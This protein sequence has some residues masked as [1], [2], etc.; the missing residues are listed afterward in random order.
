MSCRFS[1]ARCPAAGAPRS[2]R[3]FRARF[4]RSA[5]RS[6]PLPFP[7]L[8]SFLHH[9]EE[10]GDL[11]RIPVEVDPEYEIAEIVT[12]VVRED[13]PAL[14]FERPRGSRFPVVANVLGAIRRCEWALGRPPEA[15]GE[16]LLEAAEEVMPPS[17]GGLWRARDVLLRG[18]HL[19]VRY[20]RR[21]PVQA[22]VGNLDLGDLPV[23]TCWPED[24]GPFVTFPLVVTAHPE[25]GT[26]NL[27]IY[28]MH[29]YDGRRTGMHWQIMKGGGY[30]YAE[31][32]RRDEPL[33]VAVALGADPITLLASVAPLPEGID[34]LAFA[35]F[36][37]GSPTEMARCG[38]V[39]A[40]A[41]ASAEFVLEGFV[42]PDER[43][44]EGPF[45]DH[46]GH[47]SHAAPFP[48]FHLER[49]TRRRD[50]VY[51]AAVVGKPP[52]E[53]KAMGEAVAG[54]VGPLIKLV[55]PEVVDLHAFFE[56]GFHNL[57]VVAVAQ[58]YRKEAMKTALS[59]MGQ[60]Q[61][62]LTKVAILVDPDV[63]VEDWDAV[64]DAFRRHWSAAEDALLLPGVPQDTLDFTSF[65]M[66][67]GSKLALDCTSGA[68]G[69]SGDA[70]PEPEEGDAGLDE[71]PGGPDAPFVAPDEREE[72]IVDWRTWRDTLCVARVRERDGRTGRAVAESLAASPER[73]RIKW[74]AVV[75]DDVPLDDRT[76]LLW[77]IFT[78]FDAARDV[79]FSTMDMDGAW[80][81]YAGRMAIDA[82]WKPG[83]PNPIEPHPGIARRVDERWE[84]YGIS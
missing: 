73:G 41:P 44:D 10:R 38:A 33:P 66:N 25:T 82:T 51:P 74:A 52:Q 4:P 54:I 19:R 55:Q 39:E 63:A 56:A 62:A 9:C 36:L 40:A 29:V 76:L 46:F 34:E 64:L 84:E 3:G 7:D 65:R 49:I 15:I 43:A 26:R 79:V 57:L 18:R 24:G 53:D 8:Q 68:G 20:P 75:S 71:L 6:S 11:A 23:I 2:W 70:R 58:R 12:R 22:V 35:G 5:S 13:G 28:R 45:G 59:L 30:H 69:I 32:E 78:R 14:W 31:A 80:P 47:Y 60:G 61:L 50:P 21:S 1:A 83:Y 48:V 37:R 27:G 72:R 42:P 16:E 17:P 77:G 67:L 81:R